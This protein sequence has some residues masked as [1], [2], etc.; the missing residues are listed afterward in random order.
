[1]SLF[2]IS[3]AVVLGVSALCSLTE[4]ALYAVGVSYVRH[5]ADSG[6]LA[7]KALAKHKA[8]MEAPI[9]AILILNTTANTAG[10]EYVP[11]RFIL[12]DTAPIASKI[13]ESR[14]PATMAPRK[15]NRR[16]GPYFLPL[17]LSFRPLVRLARGSSPNGLTGTTL[18][19]RAGTL[20]EAI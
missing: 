17:R 1:M 6:S 2:L 11:L 14:S 4:A 18:S 16:A 3:V 8:N 7:G 13:A 9:A 5:L 20:T 15:E 10:A 12:P 19:W